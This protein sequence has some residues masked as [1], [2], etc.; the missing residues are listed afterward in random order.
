MNTFN[1]KYNEFVKICQD[2]ELSEK[3]LAHLMNL[4]NEFP[5]PDFEKKLVF[6]MLKNVFQELEIAYDGNDLKE[7]QKLLNAIIT[8]NIHYENIIN[9][10]FE[11]SEKKTVAKD[12][13]N[14]LN[15]VLENLNHYYQ[16]L[17]QTTKELT[18]EKLPALKDF[19]DTLT[20]EEY[21]SYI[22]DLMT[23]THN[24]LENPS[25]EDDLFKE[26]S[27]AEAISSYAINKEEVKEEEKE[28][29]KE[30]TESISNNLLEEPP[31][32]MAL[33]TKEERINR[34]I[35]DERQVN[36]EAYILKLYEGIDENRKRIGKLKYK[37]LQ[38]E[39][40]ISSEVDYY[41]ECVKKIKCFT[42]E[43]TRLEKISPKNLNDVY[44]NLNIPNR[45]MSIEEIYDYLSHD[46]KYAFT[47]MKEIRKPILSIGYNE[48]SIEKQE[49]P[50]EELKK[51]PEVRPESQ[52]VP[53][54]N[55]L[56]VPKMNTKMYTDYTFAEETRPLFVTEG[57]CSIK[58]I[59]FKDS[60][61]KV[62]SAF[63]ELDSLE[64]QNKGYKAFAISK[65]PYEYYRLEDVY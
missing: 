33:E 5:T 55:S 32:V 42:K 41:N 17:F 9:G 60:E 49:E 36:F 52:F 29:V 3:K 14:S 21:V 48:M 12:V 65:N 46:E 35:K 10:K 31:K 61:G 19:D 51:E 22:R 50:K 58:E 37:V 8:F 28:I 4:F 20:K 27:F 62:Y 43:A 7:Y 13:F 59:D 25:K 57:P 1:E 15:N 45:D 6:E 39:L 54:I 2:G 11:I 64:Y 34:E 53:N 38:E 26:M 18:K 44:E 63:S 16:K 56:F 47:D 24:T 23:P 40:I 30:E